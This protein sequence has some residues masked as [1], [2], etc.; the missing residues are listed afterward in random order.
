MKQNIFYNS[1]FIYF[2]VEYII[3][4]E[5][6]S[7]KNKYPI[8]QLEVLNL[9]FALQLNSFKIDLLGVFHS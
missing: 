7:I 6:I 3:V 1:I 4:Y 5:L 9:D 8:S 2:S